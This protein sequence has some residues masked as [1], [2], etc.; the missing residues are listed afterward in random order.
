MRRLDVTK[1]ACSEANCW[2]AHD[3]LARLERSGLLRRAVRPVNPKALREPA[4]SARESVV[5]ALHKTGTEPKSSTPD[6][7]AAYIKREYDTWG[8]DGDGSGI[9]R[10][11]ARLV[12][13]G[14]EACQVRV[15]PV[16]HGLIDGGGLQR[17]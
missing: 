3:R 4:P 6:E 5:A 10:H 9:S 13:V 14:G 11:L 2:E 17:A 16:V 1:W 12:D 8:S 7:F 15:C